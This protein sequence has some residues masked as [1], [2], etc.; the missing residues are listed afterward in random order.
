MDVDESRQERGGPQVDHLGARRGT[1][2]G[3]DGE[4]AVAAYHHH[5]VV[6]PPPAGRI[7][8]VSRAHGQRAWRHRLRRGDAR[9][10]RRDNQR[11]GS[12]APAR[13]A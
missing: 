7:D 11:S 3:V 12:G 10:E 5:H 6:E 8:E 9:G 4:D 13:A 2:G 1:A